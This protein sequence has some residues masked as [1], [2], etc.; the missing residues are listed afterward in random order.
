MCYAA[1]RSD[2]YVKQSIYTSV[3]VVMGYQ[4]L[5]ISKD[6]GNRCL[7]LIPTGFSTGDGSGIAGLDKKHSIFSI[8]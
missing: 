8:I 3:V 4:L 5:V 2:N 6:G 1:S 7:V